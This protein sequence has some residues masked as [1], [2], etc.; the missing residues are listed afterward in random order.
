M[1]IH[2]IT[3]TDII[4]QPW[5]KLEPSRIGRIPTGLGTPDKYILLAQRNQPLLRVDAYRSSE[6]AFIFSDAVLWHNF[7]VVGWGHCVYLIDVDSA[8][9]NKYALETYFGDIYADDDYLLVASGERIWRIHA[10]RSL[11]WQSDLLGIDGVIVDSITKGIIY[12]QGCWDPPN[13]WRPFQIR[14][15]SGQLENAP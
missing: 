7:L 6:E 15:D 1:G 8:V 5:L 11:V 12:G 2:T 13:V 3:W 14:L 4:D 9:A 10:D